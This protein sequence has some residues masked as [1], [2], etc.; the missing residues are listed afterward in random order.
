MLSID[1][2]LV[3]M[4]CYDAYINIIWYSPPCTQLGEAPAQCSVVLQTWTSE[5]VL[6]E[7]PD[8]HNTHRMTCSNMILE[9]ENSLWHAFDYLAVESGRA[10][11]SKSKLKVSS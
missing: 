5:D 6:T 1:D 3:S 10:V 4:L 11:A 2:I 8:I 9:I 7:A